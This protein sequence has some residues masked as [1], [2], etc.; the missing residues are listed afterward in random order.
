MRR[1]ILA[2]TVLAAL[3]AVAAEAQDETNG[4]PR[5]LLGHLTQGV[6]VTR[7]FCYV[8]DANDTDH[9]L[10]YLVPEDMRN[11]ARLKLGFI[12]LCIS[13]EV[14]FDATTGQRATTQPFIDAAVRRLTDANLAVL[15]DLHDNGQLKLDQDH[16]NNDAF[17]HFWEVTAKHYRGK[18]EG[19]LVFELLNEPQFLKNPDDWYALQER[20]VKAVRAVDPART[21]L[22]TGTG[23]G[24]IDTL[25]KMKPLPEKNL[26]YSYHCYDPF[27]FTHQGATW[28]GEQ[29][30]H[31]KAM[32][33]PSSPKAVAAMIGNIDPAYQGD[34]RWYGEQKF[35]EAYLKSRLNLAEAWG[36][37]NHVPVALG[38]FGAYPPV[39]PPKSRARWFEAMRTVQAELHV[40]NCLW[41]YDDGFGLGRTLASDGSVKLDPLVLKEF[42]G[43]GE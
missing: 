14:G 9:F 17:V 36:H 8:G 24:S 40:R 25:A 23:W 34:V 38:E 27:F 11:F 43:V 21:M 12:R 30:K 32:P 31:F 7:W 33:F 2:F 6:N 1:C 4:V 20:T 22:V 13:P 19:L 41:G 26:V 35:N 37:A 10:H 15:Y 29:V 39:S 16:T 28:A 18:N 5:G 3:C 42:F